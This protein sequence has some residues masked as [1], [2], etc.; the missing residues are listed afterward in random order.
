MSIFDTIHRPSSVYPQTYMDF[1]VDQDDWTAYQ[2]IDYFEANR[3]LVG[4][5]Q[6]ALYVSK[7]V[8][9]LNQFADINDARFDCYVLAYWQDE[10][11]LEFR[12]LLGYAYC[13]LSEVSKEAGA[14]T[15]NLAKILGFIT[16]PYV[17]IPLAVGVGA[18]LTYP[19]W[20][21]LIKKKRG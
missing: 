11:G 20:K 21:P 4:Q 8:S 10:M 7:D 15:D 5:A 9:E 1:P 3:T 14:I 6:A 12:T 16:K 18:A 13:G 17:I 19:Y 2:F